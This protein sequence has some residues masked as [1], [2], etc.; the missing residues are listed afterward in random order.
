MGIGRSSIIA[1][2]ILLK[3]GMIGCEIIEHI[4]LIRGLKVPDTEEQ[5]AWLMAR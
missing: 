5:L 2:A 3:H 4:S 1:A